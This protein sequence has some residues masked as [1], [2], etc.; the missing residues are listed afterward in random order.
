MENCAQI[1]IFLKN[2]GWVQGPFIVKT[3]QILTQ[4]YP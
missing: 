4:K 1:K 3:L 2:C